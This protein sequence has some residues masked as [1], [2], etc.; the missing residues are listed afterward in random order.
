MTCSL[1]DPPRLSPPPP[2]T[3]KC[4]NPKNILQRESRRGPENILQRESDEIH[5]PFIGLKVVACLTLLPPPPDGEG[6]K[7][8]YSR[9]QVK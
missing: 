6:R 1:F 5:T 9:N 7:T 4:R 8:F 3:A 2:T